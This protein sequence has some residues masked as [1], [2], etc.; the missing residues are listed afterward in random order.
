MGGSASRTLPPLDLNQFVPL[1]GWGSERRREI[2]SFDICLK[3]IDTA[4]HRPAAAVDEEAGV[5]VTPTP[6]PAA[7]S[8][9]IEVSNFLAA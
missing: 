6:A 2:S 7:K 4:A 8:S 9:W 1:A 5:P 3:A